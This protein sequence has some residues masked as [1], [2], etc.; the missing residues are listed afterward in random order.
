MCFIDLPRDFTADDLRRH[1][2]ACD[3]E[4]TKI[5]VITYGGFRIQ[6]SGKAVVCLT[7]KA[8][9]EECMSG[10]RGVKRISLEG[11]E[12][13]DVEVVKSNLAA[14]RLLPKERASRLVN[15]DSC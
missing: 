9:A 6:S 3:Y 14:G 7:T 8:M 15:D 13:Q 1:L 12:Y 11:D 10:E 2:E 4:A 5:S